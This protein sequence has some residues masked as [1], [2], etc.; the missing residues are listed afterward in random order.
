MNQLKD[1]HLI[2]ETILT[3]IGCPMGCRI[4]VSLDDQ[5]QLSVSGEQ[6]NRGAAYARSEVISPTR[7]L[8]TL[9][10]VPGCQ[11]PLSVKTSQPIPKAMI[12]DSLEAIHALKVQLPVE[13]G[14]VVIHDLLGTGSDV[15]ATRTLNPEAPPTTS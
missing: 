3:C 10:M 15:V 14:D 13:I 4:T 2:R 5:N 1:D 11:T 6:C 8:T 7:T 12:R 9:V